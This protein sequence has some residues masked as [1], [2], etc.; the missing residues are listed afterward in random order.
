MPPTGN[1][2]QLISPVLT[3]AIFIAI[4]HSQNLVL[5]TA[6]MFTSLSFLMLIS[7]PLNIVFQSVPGFMS[8]VVCFGRIEKFIDTDQWSDNQQNP[9]SSESSPLEKVP[10]TADAIEISDGSYGWA[11]DAKPILEN[12]NLKIPRGKL[13]F[14][15]GRV[16]CGKSTL[17]KAMLGEVPLAEGKIS[18]PL[19]GVAFCDQTPW[20]LNGTFKENVCMFSN[21]EDPYYDSILR[22][23]GLH[24]DLKQLLD[25]DWSNLGSKG[26]TLS[27]G[28]KQRLVSRFIL[29]LLAMLTV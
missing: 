28:Q 19:E 24:D 26:I 16:G 3:F 12:V 23:C 17:L 11:K 8:M 29:R 1:I 15:I 7:A 18:K 13:T 21:T 2:S 20:I 4:A 27:G 14:V 6:T 25:G 9:P 5:D 10:H 22:A